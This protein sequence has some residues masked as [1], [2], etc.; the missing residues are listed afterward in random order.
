MHNI[1]TNDK[2]EFAGTDY[3]AA[4]GTY[5]AIEVSYDGE[6]GKYLIEY[7]YDGVENELLQQSISH[8]F[9]G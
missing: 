5:D 4:S 9:D 8:T 2:V 3:A 7:F 1:G 6:N